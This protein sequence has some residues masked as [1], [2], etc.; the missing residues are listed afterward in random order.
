VSGAGIRKGVAWG[1]PA[2]RVCDLTVAGTDADLAAAAQGRPGSSIWWRPTRDADLARALGLV[3]TPEPGPTEVTLDA[4]VLDAAGFGPRSLAVN[5]VVLGAAP[6][7]LRRRS[8]SRAVRVEIDGRP[9]FAGSATT[10]VVANGEFLRNTD[11]IPRG[12]PGDG[13]L[14]VQVY[15]L[16]AGERRPMRS[17][18]PQGVHVPHPRITTGSGRSVLVTVAGGF[19]LEVDGVACDTQD[20][21]HLHV[22]PGALRL[23][24]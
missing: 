9:L 8:R 12:H 2:S 10:V 17:R 19:P 7:R 15:A 22:E 5:M 23:R 11:L 20:R 3:T 18:L 6:D 21:L 1:R 4:L 14:E 13:R 24:L 16:Q